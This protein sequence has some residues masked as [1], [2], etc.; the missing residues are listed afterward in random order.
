MIRLGVLGSTKGTDLVAILDAINNK[1][2][3]AEV[4]VDISTREKAYI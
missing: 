4:S 3:A 2:L 1:S